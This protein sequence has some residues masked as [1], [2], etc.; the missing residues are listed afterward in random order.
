MR[1]APRSLCHQPAHRLCQIAVAEVVGAAEPR[2]RRVARGAQQAA[3]EHAGQLVQVEVGHEEAVAELVPDRT[4]EAAVPDGPLVER[5]PHSV[6]P[7]GSHAAT[8]LRTPS[9]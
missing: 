6:T 5:A 8:A 4:P 7:N 2:E 3:V 1:T 9:S